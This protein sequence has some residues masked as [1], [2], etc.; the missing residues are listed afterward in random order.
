MYGKANFSRMQRSY[1]E[2]IR[3]QVRD[4]AEAFA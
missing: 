4:L 2:E 1:P 3:K